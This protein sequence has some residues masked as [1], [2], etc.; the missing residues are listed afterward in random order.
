[1]GRGAVT[2]KR[3]KDA[4]KT[5][6]GKTK[7][8]C[9]PDQFRHKKTTRCRN[10][11]AETRNEEGYTLFT[12]IVLTGNINMIERLLKQSKTNLKQLENITLG[13]DDDGD[14]NE[15]E[16]IVN[17][18]STDNVGRTPLSLLSSIEQFVNGENPVDVVKILLQYK[19]GDFI[20]NDVVDIDSRDITGRTSLS[21]AAAGPD[22]S[23]RETGQH[24]E[25]V[26][27]LVEN[28]ANVNSNDL[29]GDSPIMWAFYNSNKMI[30]RYLSENGA[31]VKMS[32]KNKKRFPSSMEV[33]LEK[34]IMEQDKCKEA[35]DAS[36]A[37]AKKCKDAA[38][39][40]PGRRV[41]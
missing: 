28:G 20:G 12:S 33:V 34:L 38:E 26:K 21:W 24:L 5:K 35:K 14:G 16:G 11:K 9:R 18:N 32:D 7:A 17:L 39:V 31:T 4:G 36:E 30:I 22:G 41:L 6:A 10:I 27:V 29:F 2:E 37:E 25:M 40:E 3:T 15:G 23:E 1:M 19:A 13:D 8:T